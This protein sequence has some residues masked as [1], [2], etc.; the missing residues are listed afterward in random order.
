MMDD[1]DDDNDD[2]DDDDDDDEDDD[3]TAQQRIEMLQSTKLLFE[4]EVA[5]CFKG[6]GR[7]PNGDPTPS[8][9][10]LVDWGST[11]HNNHDH[12]NHHA[13]NYNYNLCPDNYIVADYNHHPTHDAL[14]VT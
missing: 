10:L 9:D 12:D 8:N 4:A 11:N 1:D 14:L 6:I 2:D 13:Y 5:N 3:Y 7:L